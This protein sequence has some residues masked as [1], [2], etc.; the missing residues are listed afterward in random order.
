MVQKSSS[1]PSLHLLLPAPYCCCCCC[2]RRTGLSGASRCSHES[3]A[4]GS[5]PPSGYLLPVLPSPVIGARLPGPPQASAK[6]PIPD[7]L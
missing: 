6:D 1:Q 7:S 4:P 5:A 2:C 3:T